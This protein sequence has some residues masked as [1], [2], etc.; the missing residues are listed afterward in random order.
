LLVFHYSREGGLNLLDLISTDFIHSRCIRFDANGVLWVSGFT[1]STDGSTISCYK[2][3]EDKNGFSE[4]KEVELLTLLRKQQLRGISIDYLVF[5]HNLFKVEKGDYEKTKKSLFLGRYRKFVRR[6][7]YQ[8]EN[9][10][11]K[12]KK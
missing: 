9:P 6:T 5:T 10:N 7:E 2:L 1:K 3:N 4:I 11:K 12:A 8:K